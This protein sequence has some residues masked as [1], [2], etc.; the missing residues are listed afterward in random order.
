MYTKSLLS[1]ILSKLSEYAKAGE[2]SAKL[3]LTNK[4]AFSL[5]DEGFEL[6]WKCPVQGDPTR[7]LYIISW[8]HPQKYTAYQF[9]KMAANVHPEFLQPQEYHG[10]Q[11]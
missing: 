10:D 9:L 1:G 5:L 7:S 4:E 3:E 8:K 6:E 2:I 11:S